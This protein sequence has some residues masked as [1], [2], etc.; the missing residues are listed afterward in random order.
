MMVTNWIVTMVTIIGYGFRSNL[1]IVYFV[2][3]SF[4]NCYVA[5]ACQN[6]QLYSYQLYSYQPKLNET[7]NNIISKF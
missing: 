7:L 3:K 2:Q 1:K 5:K 6:Y 4:E